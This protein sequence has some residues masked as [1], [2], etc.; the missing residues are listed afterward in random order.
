MES[1]SRYHTQRPLVHLTILPR[2][3]L[4]VSVSDLL[5]REKVVV[6]SFVFSFIFIFI[7]H[8]SFFIFIFLSFLSLFRPAFFLGSAIPSRSKTPDTIENNETSDQ[9]PPQSPKE[10]V[11][12]LLFQNPSSDPPAP[13]QPPVLTPASALETNDSSGTTSNT[14]VP[15][16]KATEPAR[17]K[18]RLKAKVAEP[19]KED[20]R[21]AQMAR[22]V[23]LSSLKLC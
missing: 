12:Q 8:F 7:F 4:H 9:G 14:V 17:L 13:T 11:S 23:S 2:V 5:S 3:F 10:T 20:L 19:S 15:A 21:R 1:S 22:M 18:A 16:P 6:L